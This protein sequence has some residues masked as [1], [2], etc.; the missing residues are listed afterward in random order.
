MIFRSLFLSCSTCCE[1]LSTNLCRE[2]ILTVV[3]NN[4]KSRSR[5]NKKGKAKAKVAQ[6]ATLAPAQALKPYGGETT[7]S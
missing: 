4:G 1:Y 7:S 3:K 5:R 6:T 2:M